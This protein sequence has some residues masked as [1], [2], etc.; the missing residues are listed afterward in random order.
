MTHSKRNQ[1]PERNPP[2]DSRRRPR[3]SPIDADAVAALCPDL[4]PRR[5]AQHLERL[6]D[7]YPSRFDDQAVAAHLRAIGALSPQ[8]PVELI[9]SQRDDGVTSC[10]VIAF[11]H[12]FEFSLI[13]GMLAGAGFEITDGEVYTFAP[14]VKR[15]LQSRPGAGRGARRATS[16]LPPDR[17]SL[18]ADLADPFKRS[19]II[20]HFQGRINGQGPF[21]DWVDSVRSRMNE[22]L[23]LLNQ[24]QDA[25][26]AVAKRRVN[27]WVN[28]Y[29]KKQ[30]GTARRR[31][32]PVQIEVKE[33][34][35]GR[36]AV[37]KII[38]TDSPAFLYSL[39][40]ALSLHGLAI[41][42]V[43]IRSIGDRVEDEIRVSYRR[44]LTDADG[45]MLERIKLSVLL[46]KQFTYFLEHAPDPFAALERFE[47]LTE[48]IAQR[49]EQARWIDLL[50]DPNTMR[51][52][53][54]LL[55]SSDFLW[56]DFIRARYDT[57][58]RLFEHHRE[59]KSFAESSESLA[60]RL[61][62]AL[63]NADSIDQK[64]Q[65]LNEFKD[66]ECFLIDLDHILTP[67]ADFRELS[68]RLTLLAENLVAVASHIVY[69]QLVSTHGRPKTADDSEARYA[70]FGLGKLGGVAL[71]YASDIELLFLY[72]GLGRTVGG[73]RD[74]VDNAV[75]F[76][77]HARET[78]H[79]ISAKHEGIFEVDLRLRPYGKEGP[80]ANSIEHFA[81]YFQADGAAHP[82]E[83]LAMVRLRWIAGDPK[84]GYEVERLRNQF[85]YDQPDLDL[86]ALWEVW[87][88]QHEQKEKT[89]SLNAKYSPGALADLEGAVQLLQVKYASSAP[90]LRSPRVS[91][92]LEA[93]RRAGVLSPREFAELVSAY[94]FFRRLINRLRMLR[95]NATDLFL[96]S[97]DSAECLHLARRMGYDDQTHVSD[98]EQL[99][100][101]FKSHTAASRRFIET[102]FGRPCPGVKTGS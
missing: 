71:G 38:S 86:D 60:L 16:T 20:D 13:T 42:T 65:R 46:T 32:A 57:V 44:R 29:L 21:N 79:F 6:S 36:G 76:E 18:S 24:R 100:D 82:F 94:Y 59:G 3:S 91:G 51:S 15:S 63:E 88:R 67:N 97:V 49:P 102:H 33:S 17:R 89:G 68:R 77:T 40:T 22:V 93:L 45:F 101:E 69:E 2:S 66:N 81:G 90:Q 62:Q 50:D 80:L 56:E 64:R 34:A 48:H 30:P 4:D 19:V 92:V 23:S 55:G 26:V 37:L 25:A 7:D 8:H 14:A 11:D 1:P 75:F 10:T 9:L 28:A 41:E 39:S 70:V 99:L 31:T 96:P 52:L 54:K 84:L 73:K 12:P 58:L 87:R 53:A 98:A 78:A 74:A 43:G 35:D 85:L 83:K 95:G 27:E 5:V 72:D 47:Q 61:E